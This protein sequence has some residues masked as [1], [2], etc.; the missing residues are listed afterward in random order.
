MYN[1]A[2]WFSKYLVINMYVPIAVAIKIANVMAVLDKA[3][4]NKNTFLCLHILDIAVMRI[5]VLDTQV[6]SVLLTNWTK[7][8]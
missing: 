2:N 3:K 6:K 8:S 7:L 1:E 5:I 4:H